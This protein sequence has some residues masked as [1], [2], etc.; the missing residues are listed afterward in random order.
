M[1]DSQVT[2]SKQFG[3]TIISVE[4]RSERPAQITNS[5]LTNFVL[6]DAPR[7]AFFTDSSCLPIF[8]LEKN[9][10]TP[11]IVF[12]RSQPVFNQKSGFPLKKL[13]I[14]Y[15]FA[16]LFPNLTLS[17]EKRKSYELIF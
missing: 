3:V 14:L 13:S 5:Y 11:G 9:K 7:Q 10:S 8:G 4:S 2:V 16:A 1:N 15:L 12:F 6:A 17:A